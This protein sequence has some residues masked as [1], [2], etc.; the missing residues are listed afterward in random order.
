MKGMSSLINNQQKIQILGELWP[1]G[2]KKA[3]SSF[4]KYIDLIQSLGLTISYFDANHAE[5]L[6]HQESNLN[7][8]TDFKAYK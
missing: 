5:L 2:L 1:Y 7:F 4:Q 3:Q 8:Y 6:R